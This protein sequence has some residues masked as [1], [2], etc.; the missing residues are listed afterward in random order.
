MMFIY[1]KDYLQ[2][3]LHHRCLKKSKIHFKSEISFIIKHIKMSCD[4]AET[5]S[6]IWSIARLLVSVQIDVIF[7]DL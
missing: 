2:K 7:D 4:E 5:F 3:K 6:L 1:K